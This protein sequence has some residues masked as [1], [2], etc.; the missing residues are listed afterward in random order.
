MNS[1]CS[2]NPIFGGGSQS[3]KDYGLAFHDATWEGEF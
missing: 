2:I 3:R 1:D